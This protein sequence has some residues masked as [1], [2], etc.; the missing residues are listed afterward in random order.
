MYVYYFGSFFNSLVMDPR[1]HQHSTVK[2]E[3]ITH[4]QVH[5]NIQRSNPLSMGNH[6]VGSMSDDMSD[7][8]SSPESASFDDSDLLTTTTSKLSFPTVLSF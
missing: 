4:V 5:S 8:P 2:L 3:D 6:H 1:I 7:E